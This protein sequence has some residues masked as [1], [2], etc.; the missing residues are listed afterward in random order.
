[1]LKLCKT[2]RENVFLLFY[3]KAEEIRVE[4]TK[5]LHKV[6]SSRYLEDV[7]VTQ[8]ELQICFGFVSN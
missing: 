5:K 3:F 2:K 8:S 1:M 4:V 7:L 6:C